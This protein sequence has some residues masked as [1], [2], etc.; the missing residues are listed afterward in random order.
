MMRNLQVATAGEDEEDLWVVDGQQRTAG[1]DDQHGCA[2]NTTASGAVARCGSSELR[3]PCAGDERLHPPADVRSATWTDRGLAGKKRERD[4][5]GGDV[6]MMSCRKGIGREGGATGAREDSGQAEPRCETG[7]RGI[8]GLWLSSI[9]LQSRNYSQDV[10]QCSSDS[11]TLPS[12]DRPQHKNPI[13][14]VVCSDN[15]C[16]WSSKIIEKRIC[17]HTAATEGSGTMNQGDFSAF[18]PDSRY[19]HLILWELRYNQGGGN[20]R[21]GADRP[22]SSEEERH[23]GR[24]NCTTYCLPWRAAAHP[25][26]PSLTDIEQPLIPK[27][28]V[29]RSAIHRTTTETS[30]ASYWKLKGAL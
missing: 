16:L 4:T 9:A 21:G 30:A 13:V 24:A 25:S 2:L 14:L 11:F 5:E 23:P 20:L 1:R 3:C 26:R 18:P 10:T 22:L 29:N 7:K 12:P 27:V 6:Q 19:L 17:G 8:T 15:G 28:S